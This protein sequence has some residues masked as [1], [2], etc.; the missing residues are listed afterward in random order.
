LHVESAHVGTCSDASASFQTRAPKPA[1]QTAWH[2]LRAPV[3]SDSPKRPL[4]AA[5][6]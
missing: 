5:R 4:F 1:C 3:S 2:G 6:E